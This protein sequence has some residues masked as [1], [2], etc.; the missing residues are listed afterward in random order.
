MA[1][2]ARPSAVVGMPST[3]IVRAMTLA[4]YLAASCMTLSRRS[5]SA[6][7]ELSMAGCLQT[8]RPGL[9][10]REVGG[11]ERERD[12]DD[13]LHGLDDPRHDLVAELLLRADVEV[14]DAGAGLDLAHGQ[15]LDGL[16]RRAP[17]WPAFTRRRR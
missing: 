8:L 15:L 13:L 12:V 16:A 17:R 5:G 9:H 10:G 7:A 4:P 3:P 11:V 2:P 14:E 6:E 1:M